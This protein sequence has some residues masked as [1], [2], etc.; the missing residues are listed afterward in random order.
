[1]EGLKHFC[2]SDVNSEQDSGLAGVS[3][4]DIASVMS[5]N[6][7]NTSST[8]SSIP[9]ALKRGTQQGHQILGQ[10]LQQQVGS[11]VIFSCVSVEQGT[12]GIW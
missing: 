12:K 4:Q 10:P 2:I 8:H 3:H 9:G 6:S 1:M 11:K 7:T 5:F